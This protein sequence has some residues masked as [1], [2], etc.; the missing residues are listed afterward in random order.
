MTYSTNPILHPISNIPITAYPFYTSPTNPINPTNLSTPIK[1]IPPIS[2][3]QSQ[4]A[5]KSLISHDIPLTPLTKDLNL[6]CSLADIKT[7][8]IP[9]S[10]TDTYTDDYNILYLD[11]LIKKK[12]KNS[13]KD[14]TH[15]KREA[16]FL[17]NIIQQPQNYIAR[18]KTFQEIEDLNLK[19]SDILNGQDLDIYLSKTSNLIKQYKKLGGKVKTVLYSSDSNS[20]S[21]LSL[22]SV[23]ES[24]LSIAK[25]YLNLN[26]VRVPPQSRESCV[27][28]GAQLIKVPFNENGFKYCTE[29][30]TEH[31][32]VILATVAKDNGK[33]NLPSP[34]GDSI[35]NFLK[36]LD[37]Y[38]GLQDTVFD[39]ELFKQLD[40][41]FVSIGRK[42]GAE[43]K[44]LELN[45]RGRRGDTNHKMLWN[46][47]S[48]IQMA[49]C[50]NDANLIGHLYWGWVLPNVSHLRER[51]IDKYNRTQEGFYRIPQEERERISSIGTQFRM[52]KQLQLE[53][54]DVRIDE[55][56]IAGNSDSMRIHNRLW[57]LMCDYA[58]G[59][60]IY[61]IEG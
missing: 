48:H 10:V 8:E 22:I 11:S 1:Q 47:L 25:N 26:I 5:P 43:I 12:L 7:E 29:C 58:E 6:I 35:N 53:G 61:Y 21:D 16:E 50:Y 31:N 51:I 9:D 14:V 44:K 55:F 54:C 52:Y 46:A 39:P 19:I 23:I 13:K 24:Y 42:T 15:L 30:W 18:V 56:R 33:S 3:I 32:C 49:V 60:D 2:P 20:N 17:T 38:Q 59:D 45:S 34:D 36:V 40:E 28:C 41:Y 37:Q 57:K 27:A 4:F